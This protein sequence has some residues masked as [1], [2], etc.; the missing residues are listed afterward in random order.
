MRS[1]HKKSGEW[2]EAAM[3]SGPLQPAAHCCTIV[4]REANS[5]P[6]SVGGAPNTSSAEDTALSSLGIARR[7]NST[8]GR[9][10]CSDHLSLP[11]LTANHP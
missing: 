7:P 5:C 11:A 8:H 1:L 6:G 10:R 3:T 4:S 9:W 2:A